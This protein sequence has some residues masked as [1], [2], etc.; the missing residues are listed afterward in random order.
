[1]LL[2]VKFIQPRR[3]ARQMVLQRETAAVFRGGFPS[4]IRLPPEQR[5]P[6]GDVM[7]AGHFMQDDQQVPILEHRSLRSGFAAH[8]ITDGLRNGG[9]KIGNDL[10]VW[11]HDW[12]FFNPAAMR[13]DARDAGDW[14]MRGALSVTGRR[15]GLAFNLVAVPANLE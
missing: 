9:P 5:W 10:S 4:P 7:R 1:M 2:L 13:A 14:K 11:F 8:P 6:P 3:V 15:F 12:G